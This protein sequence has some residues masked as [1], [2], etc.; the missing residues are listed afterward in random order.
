MTRSLAAIPEQRRAIIARRRL[1]NG[2]KTGQRGNGFWAA[3]KFFE[4]SNPSVIAE[5]T[6]FPERTS[7]AGSFANGAKKSRPRRKDAVHQTT[8]HSGGQVHIKK[9]TTAKISGS[10]MPTRPS[11]CHQVFSK[12][13]TRVYRSGRTINE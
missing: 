10:S 1:E 7:N 8:T 2:T 3:V 4:Q 6:T 12:S 13:R 11:L 5:L 9:T